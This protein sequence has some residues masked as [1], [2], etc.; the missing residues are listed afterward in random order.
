SWPHQKHRRHGRAEPGF[1]GRSRAERTRAES[2]SKR[3][4]CGTWPF[5]LDAVVPA[6]VKRSAGNGRPTR[7]LNDNTLRGK[8]RVSG[9]PRPL[10]EPPFVTDGPCARMRAVSESISQIFGGASPAIQWEG[11]LMVRSKQAMV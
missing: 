7:Y 2:D 1:R 9:H 8:S 11:F 5:H 4:V 10:G 3:K 6:K